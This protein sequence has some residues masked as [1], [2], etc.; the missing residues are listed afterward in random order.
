VEKIE[1]SF[2]VGFGYDSHRFDDEPKPLV[3]GGVVF[4]GERGLKAH[5][6]GDV[7]IHAVIDALLGAAA[8]GDIGSHFPD[9][10]AKWKGAD[11]TKLLSAVVD[12]IS[13]AGYRLGNLDVTVICERT[14]IR[15]RVDEIRE[16]LAKL[17]KADVSQI[18]VKGKTNEKLDD[19]GAGLGIEVHAVTLLEKE[20]RN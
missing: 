19:I 12:E 14:R 3:L 8:M 18:S 4:D 15:P 5:S 20:I 10:D 1:R 7:V 2:K 6:D 9:T 13:A 16:S 17:L 11:S